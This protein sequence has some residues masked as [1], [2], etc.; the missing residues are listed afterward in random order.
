MTNQ[1][2]ERQTLPPHMRA[3][4]DRALAKSVDALFALP[5]VDAMALLNEWFEGRMIFVLTPGAL[6]AR[7]VDDASGPDEDAPR[8]PRLD[9]PPTG[10][11]L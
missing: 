7:H 8:L 10:G 5:D 3:E 9:D 4:F 1:P 11:Y 6:W 2:D